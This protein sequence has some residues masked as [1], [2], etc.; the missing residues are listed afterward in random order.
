MLAPVNAWVNGCGFR[1]AVSA[2]MCI[3]GMYR[4]YRLCQMGIVGMHVDNIYGTPI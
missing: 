2:S 3:D 4:L 1:S